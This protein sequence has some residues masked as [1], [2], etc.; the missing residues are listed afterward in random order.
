MQGQDFG[1]A[2][3]TPARR[4]HSAQRFLQPLLLIKDDGV[5][6]VHPWVR[7]PGRQ[8]LTIQGFRFD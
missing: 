6:I 2:R 1:R 4:L 7:D 5:L 8:R 3:R